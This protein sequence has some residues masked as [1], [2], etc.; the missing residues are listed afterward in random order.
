[1]RGENTSIAYYMQNPVFKDLNMTVLEY[2][3]E[4]AEIIHMNDGTTLSSGQFLEQ[5]GFEGKILH[6][7]LETLSGG[8]RKRLFLVRLLISNPNFS[9]S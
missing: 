3:K 6:S 8:E 7:P 5:F 2:I 1:M 9:Y 4:A